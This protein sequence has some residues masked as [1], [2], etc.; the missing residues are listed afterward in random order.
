ME[1]LQNILS[2]MEVPEFRKNDMGW[3]R[4][5]LFVHN[6]NHLK[7]GIA[8]SLIQELERKNNE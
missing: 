2:T 7:F 6:E 8:M 1:E 3:L 4:R 5:N